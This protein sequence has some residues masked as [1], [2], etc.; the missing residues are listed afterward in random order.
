MSITRCVCVTE[1]IADK[2]A[3]ITGGADDHQDGRNDTRND[4]SGDPAFIE[5]VVEAAALLP[6]VPESDE[7]LPHITRSIGKSFVQLLTNRA[8][9]IAFG[10][11]G[12]GGGIGWTAIGAVDDLWRGGGSGV[13]GGSV[14]LGK[15]KLVKSFTDAG[16]VSFVG[17]AFPGVAIAVCDWP[18]GE[19][20][21]GVWLDRAPSPADISTTSLPLVVFSGCETRNVASRRT[22][23]W[24]ASVARVLRVRKKRYWTMMCADARA[25][26]TIAEDFS[27]RAQE[28]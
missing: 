20:V 10:L 21:G 15:G 24:C 18:R 27:M 16:R 2:N 11:A 9:L 1:R 23:A 19:G 8:V 17:L 22:V 14:A 25:D 13:G 3:C 28:R 5:L 6:R 26:D 12:A 4:G 7:S